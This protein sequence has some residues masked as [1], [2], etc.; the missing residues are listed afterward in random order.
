MKTHKMSVTLMAVALSVLVVLQQTPVVALK[1]N[2]PAEAQQSKKHEAP[3]ERNFD[4]SKEIKHEL[5]IEIRRLR[6]TLD[7]LTK[8]TLVQD[9]LRKRSEKATTNK[10]ILSIWKEFMA[11][12]YSY[13]HDLRRMSATCKRVDLILKGL[14]VSPDRL[15]AQR[16]AVL[17]EMTAAF[18]KANFPASLQQN[19]I[20][21]PELTPKE[22]SLS[23]AA[24]QLSL[25]ADAF[26]KS[27]ITRLKRVA[28]SK[29]A[30]KE[31]R[32]A[33]AY[34]GD[35]RC[36]RADPSYDP[37]A[38]TPIPCLPSDKGLLFICAVLFVVT[39]VAVIIDLARE[40]ETDEGPRS[41]FMSASCSELNAISTWDLI[42]MIEA[43]SRGPTLDGDEQAIL[44]L[45]GCLPCARVAEL[46]NS[47]SIVDPDSGR[48]GS[49][50]LYDFDGDEFDQL[51]VRLHECGLLRFEDFDDDA[52]RIFINTNECAVL[53]RLSNEDLRRL[54]LHLFEDHTGDEDEAAIIKLIECLPLYRVSELLAMPGLSYG[55]FYDEVDGSE[56]RRL[57]PTLDAARAAWGP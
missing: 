27:H 48:I 55:D 40:A 42:P 49:R 16:N 12:S 31:I 37:S 43:L 45:F 24:K 28:D 52:T 21:R 33:T 32:R 22:L 6:E 46:W 54:I 17:A 47:N 34:L 14:G 10:D 15:V 23:Y 30:K 9:N 50:L 11:S 7:S 8:L 25:H 13:G 41:Q 20:R 35:P 39:V 18:R 26:Q 3:L 44:R 1:S 38:C 56:W 53:S 19:L 57:H 4:T 29:E 51:K 2:Q 5:G 36:D